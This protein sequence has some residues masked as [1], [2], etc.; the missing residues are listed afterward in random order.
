MDGTLTVPVLKFSEM[1]SRLGLSPN[2]D[3]LP[4]VQG[5]PPDKRAWAMAI[6]EEMEEE[7]VRLMQVG[8]AVCGVRVEGVWL[9]QVSGAVCDVRVEEGVLHCCHQHTV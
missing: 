9:M 5:F 3:I 2:Q 8:G 4:T 6:I 7:G 1:R